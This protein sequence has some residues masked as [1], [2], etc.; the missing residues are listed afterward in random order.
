MFLFRIPNKTIL[1]TG[2]FRI[3]QNDV[4]KYLQLHK[5]GDPIKIDVMYVDTTFIDHDHP[6]FAK[7]SDSVEEMLENID[8]WLKEDEYNRV[9]IHTSAEYGYEFVFNKI[10]KRLGEKV[11]VDG[12]I[13]QLYKCFPDLLPALKNDDNDPKIHLCRRIWD[14]N[15]CKHNNNIQNRYLSV[16]FSAR[17]WKNYDEETKSCEISGPD[18]IKVLY[19]THCSRSELLYFVN[20][21]DPVKII[22]FPNPYVPRIKETNYK[23]SFTPS[24]KKKKL[25][26]AEEVTVKRKVDRKLLEEMFG[27]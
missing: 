10:Y 2:D 18:V 13:W 26:A 25:E 16:F 6:E 12:G 14:K 11:A 5:K 4:H 7:R 24:P 9:A 22:G 23:D 19:A 1:Y 15:D 21:L 17:S 20:Y 3:R 8:V 27:V